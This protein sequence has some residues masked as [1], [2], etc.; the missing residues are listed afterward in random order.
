MCEKKNMTSALLNGLIGLCLSLGIGMRYY[1]QTWTDIAF[2]VL[3]SNIAAFISL[4]ATLR[5]E[6]VTWIRKYLLNRSIKTWSFLTFFYFS[7]LLSLSPTLH[8]SENFLGLILPLILS[9]GFAII[10]F[11]PIQDRLVRQE[12][13]KNTAS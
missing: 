10:G 8:S 5:A 12:Q 1:D 7:I 4:L 13:R 2:T 6:R 9:T 11:G 3:A